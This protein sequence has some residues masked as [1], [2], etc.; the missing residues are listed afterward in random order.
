MCEL[1]PDGT[2]R[3]LL[4]P[5]TY[6]QHVTHST[7]FTVL[8]VEIWATGLVVNIHLASE[9]AAEPRIILQDHFGTEYSFRNSATVGSRN[10]QVFTPSVPAGTRSLTVRSAD[11]PDSRPVVTFAVPLMALPDEAEPSQDGAQRDGDY[12]SPQLRRP[13]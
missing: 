5:P 1:I 6:G 12:P 2:L 4:L 13:A 9:D 10:L 3:R 8:S 7:E 11:D